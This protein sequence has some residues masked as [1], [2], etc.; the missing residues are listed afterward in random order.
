MS[1]VSSLLGATYPP[2]A[3]VPSPVDT[4]APIPVTI[5]PAQNPHHSFV[6]LPA[7]PKSHRPAPPTWSPDPA[8]LT[9]GC[10]YI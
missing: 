9:G 3:G 4:L 2:L 5:Q 10:I 7:T 6:G 1:H 8:L